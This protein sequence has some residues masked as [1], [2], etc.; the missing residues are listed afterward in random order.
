MNERMADRFPAE[1]CDTV[2]SLPRV[3]KICVDGCGR[4]TDR[5]GWLF[6]FPTNHPCLQRFTCHRDTYYRK[7]EGTCRG[8]KESVVRPCERSRGNI[9]RS[10]CILA[11]LMDVSEK[12]KIRASSLVEVSRM[13]CT[14]NWFAGGFT[15]ASHPREIA[16]LNC[17]HNN[18]SNFSMS[19]RTWRFY[20]MRFQVNLLDRY[21][22]SAPVSLAKG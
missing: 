21:R 7:F 17:A 1:R 9:A 11:W 5:H 14:C 12:L 8:S 18:D 10:R 22:F 4:I 20:K 19:P 15:R 16:I 3:I 13:K 2:L 6:Q